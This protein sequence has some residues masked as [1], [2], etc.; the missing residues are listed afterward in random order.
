MSHAHGVRVELRAWM[1]KNTQTHT[2]T[3]TH[4]C[5]YTH[6]RTHTSALTRCSAVRKSSPMP[7][8]CESNCTGGEGRLVPVKKG[9]LLYS[10]IDSAGATGCVC[11]CV[12][13]CMYVYISF[14]LRKEFCCLL[15]CV[16]IRRNWM[17]THMHIPM[18]TFR[19][20]QQNHV[21]KST[22]DECSYDRVIREG[23]QKVVARANYSN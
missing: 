2:N 1:S 9:I 12:C 6:T 16:F 22:V 7:M 17:Y 4:V 19:Y 18:H 13:V 8:A 11:V 21:C 23:K 14:P 5:M 10:C 20:A 15:W 3:H